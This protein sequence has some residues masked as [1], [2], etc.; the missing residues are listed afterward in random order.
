MAKRKS[1]TGKTDEFIINK[2][3]TVRDKTVMLDRDLA[4]LYG[5]TTYRLN[6]QVKRNRKRFPKDFMFQLT[7]KEKQALIENFPHLESLKYSPSLPKVFTEHG[8]VM[9]A[10]VLNS[11][12]AIE[13]NIRIV[14][15]FTKMRE[16]LLS[17]KDVLLK[18][19][20]LERQT[21]KNSEDI[22][23]V[24]EHL[25]QLILPQTQTT[26]RRIGFRRGSEKDD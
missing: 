9:L 8:A 15:I 23:M 18:I 3:I 13:V 11:Q 21:N 24:F 7:K 16:M 6:E 22:S 20:K 26:R 14:R 2:I 1:S 17:Y 10:S 4:E 12:R 19:E 5:V 25:R